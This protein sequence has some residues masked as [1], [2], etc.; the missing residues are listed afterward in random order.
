MERLLSDSMRCI[1]TDT[2]EE[3]IPQSTIVSPLLQEN[4]IH[5]WSLLYED[6]DCHFKVL[7][8]LISTEEWHAASLFK[9]E[10]HARKYILRHGVL[11]SILGSCTHRD[12]ETI[13]FLRGKNGK[14]ELDLRGRYH[15]VSFNL[16]HTSEMVVIGITRKQ[17]IGIDIVKMDSGYCYQDIAEY[18][19]TP[20]EKACMQKIEPVMRYQVF[21]RIWT[22]KEA[23]LKTNGDTLS[24]MRET[25]T[26]DIIR[27]GWSVP[28]STMKYPNPLS[29]LF[30]W[31]FDGGNGHCGAIAAETELPAKT[32]A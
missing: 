20:A 31:Q 26:S 25:D 14:P 21:F 24:A 2:A 3:R 23:I 7:S 29:P 17:R 5:I 28:C 8:G 30:I 22:L 16:S 9:N 1:G 19:L 32:L 13:S 11:R 18:I 10:T 4:L 15:D 27:E 12:P 6:L